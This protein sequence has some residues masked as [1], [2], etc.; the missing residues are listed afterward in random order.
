M[1][2]RRLA[3]HGPNRGAQ[4]PVSERAWPLPDD[5]ARA[6][7]PG[8]A[9]TRD[10]PR[11]TGLAPASPWNAGNDQGLTTPLAPMAATA[12]AAPP[13]RPFTL[14]VRAAGELV[15]DTA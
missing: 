11:S 8:T 3:G 2:R 12:S 15:G 9:L 13:S 10:K 5:V 4:I 7:P 14:G 1:G 6:T